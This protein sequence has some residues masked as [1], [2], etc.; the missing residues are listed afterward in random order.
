MTT[1]HLI[2]SSKAEAVGVDAS[3]IVAHTADVAVSARVGAR[4]HIWQYVYIGTNV[5]IG[6]GCVLGRSVCVES[7]AIIGDRVKIQ[8]G[9]GVF[10]AHIDD[11]AMLAPGVYLLEDPTPRAVAPTGAVK[12]DEDWTRTPVSIGRGATIGAGAVVAPGVRIGRHALVA[13]ASAVNRDV[14]DHALVAGN[15]ARQ[16]G[17]VCRC[18]QTLAEDLTCS[19]CQIAYRSAPDGLALPP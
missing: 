15:P 8:T 7:A 1:A 12:G 16:V 6:T 13:I 4:T 5:S 9:C 11:E 19:P 17:W 14:P 10:G 3:A 2:T 18:G